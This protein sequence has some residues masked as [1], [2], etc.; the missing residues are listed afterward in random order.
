MD[1]ISDA[2]AA[3]DRYLVVSELNKDEFARLLNEAAAAG[4]VVDKF[5]TCEAGTNSTRYAAILR[6]AG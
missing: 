5:S 3:G 4:Y 6:R 2:I 1:D